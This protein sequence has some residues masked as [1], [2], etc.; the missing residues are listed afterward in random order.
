MLPCKVLFFIE[1]FSFTYF[2]YSFVI[3]E[4]L[5]HVFLLLHLVGNQAQLTRRRFELIWLGIYIFYFFSLFRFFFFLRS[6]GGQEH[7]SAIIDIWW[8]LGGSAATGAEASS[9]NLLRSTL[10]SSLAWH[11]FFFA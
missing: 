9:L 1:V 5:D 3:F 2:T 10:S 7:K 11:H 8:Q 4:V 6:F